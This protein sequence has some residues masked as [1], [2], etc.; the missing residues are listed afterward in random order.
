MPLP[1]R[2]DIQ[3]QFMHEAQLTKLIDEAYDRA[4]ENQRRREQV[5]WDK[6]NNRPSNP[7]N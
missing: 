6:R 1:I 2:S 7:H 3:E 4:Y 5:L